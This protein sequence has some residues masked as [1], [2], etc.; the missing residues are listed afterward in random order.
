MPAAIDGGDGEGVGQ[1]IEGQRPGERDDVAA[2][3]QPPAEAALLGAELVEM[4]ARGVLIESRRD[5][6]LGLFDRI[7]VDMVDLFANFVIAE[8]IGAAGKREIVSVDIERGTGF[9]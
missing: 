5:L 7:A 1:P 3:D 8:T 2:V 6:M 4:D 9:A